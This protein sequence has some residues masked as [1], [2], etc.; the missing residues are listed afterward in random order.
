MEP[1]YAVKCLCV[2]RVVG[3]VGKAKVAYSLMM[4][5]QQ[6]GRMILRGPN[7]EVVEDIWCI[8]PVKRGMDEVR[9]EREEDMSSYRTEVNFRT[10]GHA[11][12]SGESEGQCTWI[13][14]NGMFL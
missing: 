13:C 11:T 7:G 2:E 9:R 6:P 14:S 10:V 8:T 3:G 5:E 12:N 1:F 4:Y